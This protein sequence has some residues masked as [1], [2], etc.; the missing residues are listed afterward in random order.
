[1][2]GTCR[3]LAVGALASALW[4]GVAA[5]GGDDSG[6]PAATSSTPAASTAPSTG[7]D[8][9][10]GT[11]PSQTAAPPSPASAGI[12]L[13]E[14]TSAVTAPEGWKPAEPLVDYASSADGPARYDSLQLADRPSLSGSSDLDE[15]AASFRGSLPDGARLERLP[16][17]D[18]AGSP[19]Y[20]FH[21]TVPGDPVVYDSVSTLRNGRSITVDFFLNRSTATEQPELVD[22]VLGTFRWLG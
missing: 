4:L 21:W 11:D 19:A 7:A 14:E 6:S 20:H 18:L 15:L 13:V 1:M 12:E 17:L 9:Q 10:T 2:I 22:S 3:R 8:T 16:D 5:C